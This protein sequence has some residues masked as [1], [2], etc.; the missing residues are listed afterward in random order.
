MYKR[1]FN[2]NNK[3]TSSVV[4]A[5]SISKNGG[6]CTYRS[7]IK[8]SPKIR[9]EYQKFLKQK[10]NEEDTAKKALESLEEINKLRNKLGIDEEDVVLLY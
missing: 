5:K 8:I 1:R 2:H 10:K 3:N 7:L 9:I 6:K 4:N